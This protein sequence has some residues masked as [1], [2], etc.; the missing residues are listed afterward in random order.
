MHKSLQNQL[1][2]KDVLS[3]IKRTQDVFRANLPQI[4]SARYP[5]KTPFF[6]RG[7]LDL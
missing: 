7:D 5:L 2:A 3:N 6:V 4:S 1:E